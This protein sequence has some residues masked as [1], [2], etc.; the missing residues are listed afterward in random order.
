MIIK[1]LLVLYEYMVLYKALNVAYKIDNIPSSMSKLLNVPL[2]V[3]AFNRIYGVLHPITQQMN[4][5]QSAIFDV[6]PDGTYNAET[7]IRMWLSDRLFAM[8]KFMSSQNLLDC[9]ILDLKKIDDDN[10]LIVMSPICMPK[11][12]ERAIKML[13]EILILA[14]IAIYVFINIHVV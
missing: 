5:G 11:L 10:Y 13:Y 1:F 9:L 2:H 12:K 4:N 6:N 7:S 14:A 8:S 3:D